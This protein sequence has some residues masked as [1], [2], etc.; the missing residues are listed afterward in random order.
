MDSSLASALPALV[1]GLAAHSRR[2]RQ[3]AAQK[4]YSIA[5]EDPSAILPYL[6]DLP[7]DVPRRRRAGKCLIR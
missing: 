5:K 6:N 7:W 2:Q 1:G 4:V 3:A